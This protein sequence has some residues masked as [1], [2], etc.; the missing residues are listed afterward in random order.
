[1]RSWNGS[2]KVRSPQLRSETLGATACGLLAMAGLLTLT[3]T[4]SA[5]QLRVSVDQ[6]GDFDMIGNSLGYDCGNVGTAPTVGTVGACGLNTI[7]TAPDVFWRSDDQLGIAAANS[8]I[9][10]ANARST[11]VLNLPAG[12]TVTHAFLYWAG[13]ST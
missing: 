8:A 2:T 7:D 10:A 9:T 3:S 13:E 11:A 6:A 4:A 12:A 5:Q 1:M